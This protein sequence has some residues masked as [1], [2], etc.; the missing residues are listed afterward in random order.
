VQSGDG[1]AFGLAMKGLPKVR[2]DF[3]ERARTGA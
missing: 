1:L 3:M 2:P